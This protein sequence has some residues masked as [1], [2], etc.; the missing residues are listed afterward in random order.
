MQKRKRMNIWVFKGERNIRRKRYRESGNERDKTRADERDTYTRIF[1]SKKTRT[2]IQ[3]S[4]AA[5]SHA[6]TRRT[7]RPIFLFL[8]PNLVWLIIVRCGL[9]Y[10]R[11]KK[12]TPQKRKEDKETSSSEKPSDGVFPETKKTKGRQRILRD[13]KPRKKHNVEARS[14][15]QYIRFIDMIQQQRVE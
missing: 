8:S 6:P 10:I 12:K 4:R 15:Y 13:P 3:N 11:K 2:A 7:N 5:K 1:N 14:S 9:S